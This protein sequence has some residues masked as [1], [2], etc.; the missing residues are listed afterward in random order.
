MAWTS[1]VPL[2]QEHDLSNFDCGL[3][4]VDEWFKFKALNN[5]QNV[6]THLCTR[7]PSEILA[8]FALKTIIV[9]TQGMNSAQRAGSIDG[10]STGILLCW[11]GLSKP[12]HKKGHGKRLLVE[13]MRSAVSS[14]SVSPVQLFVVDAE[15]EELVA[16]YEKAGLKLLPGTLRLVAPMKV[17]VKFINALTS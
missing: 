2:T 13:A 12:L 9:A 15:N 8:F 14:H 10:Q 7:P 3:D 11:M 5:R 4:A 1:I 6:A 17:I 16:F